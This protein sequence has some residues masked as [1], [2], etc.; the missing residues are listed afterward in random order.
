[1]SVLGV[2]S[3]SHK[4]PQAYP[5]RESAPKNTIK[6]S[7]DSRVDCVRDEYANYYCSWTVRWVFQ[8]AINCWLLFETTKY[9]TMILMVGPYDLELAATTRQWNQYFPLRS[10]Y[11]LFLCF[12]LALRCLVLGVAGFACS[13][14]PLTGTASQFPSFLSFCLLCTT[15]RLFP[16]VLLVRPRLSCFL[17]RFS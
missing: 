12:R 11:I 1:M 15:A 6:L 8:R 17:F 9:P 3:C 13:P 14:L 5:E 2:R 7:I 4:A 16:N 10:L